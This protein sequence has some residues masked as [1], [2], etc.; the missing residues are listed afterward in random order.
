MLGLCFIRSSIL[1]QY[2]FD[3]L[4]PVLKTCFL[5][6]GLWVC[7]LTCAAG[8]TDRI[9]ER[10]FWTDD[11]G[12][13]D[14]NKAQVQK[15]T[16][17]QGVL[18]KGYTKA[19][20]WIKLKIN[21]DTNEGHA[22]KLVLRMR[23]TYLDEIQLFDPLDTANVPRVTGDRSSYD[24][25][26]YESL[27]HTFVIPMG[28]QERYIYLRVKTTSTMLLYVEA[29]SP[30]D[31]LKAEHRMLVAYFAVLAMI[32]VFLVLVFF[33]WLN[34][35][36]SLYAVFVIRHLV[37]L[38]FTAGFFGFG[39][40][41]LSEWVSAYWLDA[42]YNWLV[43]GTTAFSI[44]FEYLFLSEYKPPSWA[45]RCMYV[46]LTIPGIIAGLLLMGYTQTALNINM[47]LNGVAV[48][49]YLLLASAFINDAQ[50]KLSP[51][52]SL[53]KRRVVVGYYFLLNLMLWANVLPA[54]GLVAGD[55]FALNGLISYSLC[56]GIVMTGLMQLRANQLK[57]SNLQYSQDLLLSKQQVEL[58]KIK[59]EEQSQLLAMLMHEL[60]NPLA[61]IDMAQ[62]AASDQET[63][64]YVTRNVTII[65]DIL[66]RCLNADRISNG[67]LVILREPVNMKH[68]VEDVLADQPDDAHRLQWHESSEEMV[69]YTDAQC[70]RIVLNNLI[71][72]ALRYGDV[73]QPVIVNMTGYENN[74]Q[75]CITVSNKPGV[76]GWPDPQNLFQKYY[77]STGAK[78]ISGT[79]L[80]LFLVNSIAIVLGA[81]CRYTPDDKYI[82]FELCLPR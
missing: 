22:D 39:R 1:M 60:K 19:P 65:K 11:S 23:P 69:V 82:R 71:A 18:S 27:T 53:L 49:S 36:E 66:D 52:N 31:M 15:F 25:A 29:L 40:L 77:R 56:S 5:F 47:T 62:H 32:A 73:T 64:N 33:N 45:K 20:L 13:A 42:I 16:P 50:T 26:E 6:I 44:W 80:G 10:A 59:R 54:L 78:S 28:E 38:V 17:Y 72:N 37:Y 35:K 63:Q 70:V 30:E 4:L 21:P 14:V 2:L 8:A 12:S 81:T 75:V 24:A 58:E 68:L 67:K 3:K 57:Q 34:Y 61:V 55:E 41:L 74:S 48:L 51:T 46:L 7:S 76:A 79:G 9:S 43:I